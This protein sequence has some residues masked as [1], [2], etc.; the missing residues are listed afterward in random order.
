MSCITFQ[1][2]KKT[3]YYQGSSYYNISVSKFALLNG[4]DS[5]TFQF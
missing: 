4:V 5:L 2:E 3:K 1:M